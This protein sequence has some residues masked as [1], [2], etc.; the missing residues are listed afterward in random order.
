MIRRQVRDG[1]VLIT[2]RCA[3]VLLSL[4][5]LIAFAAQSRAQANLGPITV[6][7]G[8]Q[9]SFDHVDTTGGG[10]TDD[11]FALNHARI[12]I[13]GPVT[14]SI[15]FM[16]NTD[17]DS[18]SNKIGVL[19]A[20]AEFNFAPQFHIWAGRFLEPSDRANLYGP[21]YSNEFL[22]FTDG[23]QDGYSS[24]Y[25]GRDNGVMYWGD[26]FKQRM[27]VSAGAFDGKSATGK[28]EVLGAARVQFDFWDKED[29]YYL[30]GTYYGD[31]NLLA[32]GGASQYQ[33]GKV[34]ST[35]DFLL[36][37]KLPNLGV[38]TIESEYSNYNGLGGYQ[39]NYAKSQGAYALVSYL[40]PKV[41][42]IGKIT[43]KFQLL[44]KYA[45]ADFTH[46]TGVNFDQKTVEVNLNY[47]IKQ[48]NARIM[49]FYENV[50]FNNV[51]PD[52]W[53]A[54]LGLQIQI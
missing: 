16:F 12:Y 42:P 9:T 20:V 47:V 33:D 29:G 49:S 19:D 48:F 24:I 17:Y 10:P 3:P 4:L 2:R 41:I 45:K 37:K 25:Q 36:E 26:F 54:G 32:I 30:N 52:T 8:L 1:R 38:F 7:A 51:K 15:S 44:A 53:Q 27:K 11:T 34:G 5:G 6:G 22:A 43:G 18:T 31:K 28:G 46:G 23:V 14:D 13:N 39:A 50:N 35:I 40:F 21:F